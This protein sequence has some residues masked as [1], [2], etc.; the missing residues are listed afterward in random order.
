MD[1]R[2]HSNEVVHYRLGT[3]GSRDRRRWT[4]WPRVAQ[5]GWRRHFYGRRAVGPRSAYGAGHQRIGPTDSLF[6]TRCRRHRKPWEVIEAAQLTVDL[7]ALAANWQ[8]LAD[9]VAPARCG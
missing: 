7:T 4:R 3:S 5:P 6:S 8:L 9:Q 2:G 1:A